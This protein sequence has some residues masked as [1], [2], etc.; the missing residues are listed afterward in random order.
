MSPEH[1]HLFMK[2]KGKSAFDVGFVSIQH[3]LISKLATKLF[4]RVQKL[5]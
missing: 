3:W 1:E 2:C 4:Q 5:I